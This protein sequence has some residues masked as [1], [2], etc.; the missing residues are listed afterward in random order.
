MVKTFFEGPEDRLGEIEL[1]AVVAE[2]IKNNQLVEGLWVK[3]LAD[4]K[5]DKKQARGLYSKLTQ[6]DGLPPVSRI[7]QP[8]RTRSFIV[9]L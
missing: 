4:C 2:E 9:T 6:V 3:A 8:N 7:I 5:G 1:Y